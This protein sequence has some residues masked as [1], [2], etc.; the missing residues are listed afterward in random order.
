MQGCLTPLLQPVD[1]LGSLAKFID[2]SI[3]LL[4]EFPSID[5]LIAFTHE[6]NRRN[7]LIKNFNHVALSY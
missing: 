5:S 2:A 4:L 1:Q 3:I 6:E 7:F